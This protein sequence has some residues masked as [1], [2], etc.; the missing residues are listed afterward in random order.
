M[1]IKP[2]T[3]A[4]SAILALAMTGPAGR[5]PSAMRGPDRAGAGSGD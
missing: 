5:R 4:T 1:T 2:I 3:L